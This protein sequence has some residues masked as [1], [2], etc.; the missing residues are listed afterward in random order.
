MNVQ[1]LLLINIFLD[2]YAKQCYTVDSKSWFNQDRERS[3]IM[4]V[5]FEVAVN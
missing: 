1:N 4:G 2:Y 5:I 3:L